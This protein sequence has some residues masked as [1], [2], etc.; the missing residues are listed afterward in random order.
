MTKELNLP[1]VILIDINTVFT[2]NTNRCLQLTL[3][4]E[5]NHKLLLA[6]IEFKLSILC[7]CFINAVLSF[8]NTVLGFM[9]HQK[10]L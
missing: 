1:F 3:K 2:M 4:G 7:L 9:K 6:F 10:C 5:T 8:K